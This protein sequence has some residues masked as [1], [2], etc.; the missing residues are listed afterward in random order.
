MYSLTSAQDGDSLQDDIRLC[1]GDDLKKAQDHSQ[2]Q[3]IEA[4]RL[5]LVY[6]S[7]MGF[8]VYQMDVKSA[9]LYG[10][11]E[12]EVYVCQPPGFEDPDYPDKVYKVVKALY[13][14]HQALRACQDKY[15]TDIFKK[16]GFQ[17][18]RTTSTPMH[19]EKPLLKDSDGDDVDVHLYMSMIR[20]LMYL[21]SSRPDI[22]FA[23][24]Q[25][26]CLKLN[27]S[28][29]KYSL[30]GGYLCQAWMEGHVISKVGDEAVHKELGDIMKRVATAA[31]SLEAEQDS[32]FPSLILDV[33]IFL[34]NALFI[35]Y[36]FWG[37]STARTTNDGEVEIT[38]SIDEQVKTI[39]KASLRRHLKLE[40]SDGI[41][42]LTNTEIFEQLALM[43]VDFPLFP[44]MITAPESSPS[45]ITS[46]PSVSP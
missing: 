24:K 18:V 6:A 3:A 11:I 5:F 36:R 9:F 17:D 1:L 19:T 39:T 41:T 20:S 35:A 28:P 46:S 25:I 43:G 2:R 27:A 38:V 45:R 13:R 15:V 44:T 40:D 8:M 34:P 26:K 14:L 37:T 22:M 4:I 30:R 12:E 31:S 23:D 32:E 16:F 10:Q 7:F 42:S 21:T 29:I 33:E